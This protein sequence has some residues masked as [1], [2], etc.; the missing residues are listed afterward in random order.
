MNVK[1]KFMKIDR[2]ILKI[3][4]SSPFVIFQVA[5]GLEQQLGRRICQLSIV[6]LASS[7]FA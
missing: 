7:S 2:F 4:N 6:L 5:R 3:L 1:E